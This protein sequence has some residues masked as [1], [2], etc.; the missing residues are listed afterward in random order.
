MTLIHQFLQIAHQKSDQIALISSEE[1]CTYGD[2]LRRVEGVAQALVAR[3]VGHEDP[4]GISVPRSLESVIA[5]LGILRA[6]GAYVP[7]DPAYPEARQALMARDAGLRAVVSSS[8]IEP[9]PAWTGDVPVITVAGRVASGPPL[10]PPPQN[11]HS[12]LNILYT[13][14]ST[15]QPKGVLGTHAAMLNRLRWGWEAFPFQASEVVGHRSS[16]NFVDAG[17][18][19]FSGLLQGIPTAILLEDEMADLSRLVTALQCHQVTRL[20][21]VPSILTSILRTVTSLQ[22]TLSKL[23]LWISSGEELSSSLLQLF[24]QSLPSATLINLYG[25]TEVTGDVTCAVFRPDTP[26]PFD[27]VPIGKAIAGADLRI[28]DEYGNSV[29][30]GAVGELHVGGPVLAR[31]YLNRPREEAMRFPGYPALGGRRLFRTGDRVRQ[32]PDGVVH[33]LGRRDNC[34][35]IRGVRVDLEEIEQCLKAACPELDD[36]A[37]VLS[38]EGESLV[39]FVMPVEAD[40]EVVRQAAERLLPATLRPAR[41]VPV[42]AFPYLPNGKLD[43]SQLATRARGP[44]RVLPP[45]RLPET[46]TEQRLAFLWSS[47]L[48]RSDIGKDDTFTGL[49]GDS[50]TLAE[51]MAALDSR[52]A[53][54]RLPLENVRNFPLSRLA[55]VL[56]GQGEAGDSGFSSSPPGASR[57]RAITL[58]FMGEKASEDATVVSL[59]VEA[60]ADPVLTASTELP[61]YMDEGMA[62]GYIRSKEGVV[63][64]VEGVPVGA[65]V[66][67][68]QPNVG[69]GVTLPPGGIQLDEWLLQGWRGAGILGEAGAWP[70][71]L[72]WLAERYD[73]EVSVVW[74]DHVAMLAILRARGYTRLGRSY[75]TSKVP[76]EVIAGYCEV[77]SLDLRPFRRAR[78][79]RAG[80]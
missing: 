52:F 8:L 50:L 80:S 22:S 18:E 12:L 59:F 51:L 58:S 76:N 54:V 10:P 19:I 55:A 9:M 75:W 66:V 11:S 4:V 29:G 16:L 79:D 45:E 21:V 69:E 57:D 34:V 37:A 46:P 41:Y 64:W 73:H 62:R 25:T 5:V 53:T 48:R 33:Y 32:T 20:T 13:S 7:I 30:E 2:L 56:D 65:G 35:K 1:T 3:G 14:G 28:L 15:G 23:Q 17:P 71:I 6:G 74:E 60:S 36:C 72:A 70:M 47:L 67:G 39:A 31:G 38:S 42:A 24:R 43:R 44:V 40:C 68:S 26:M 78:G 49:G 63:I 27:R 77:W 61:A